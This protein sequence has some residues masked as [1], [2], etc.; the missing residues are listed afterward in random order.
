MIEISLAEWLALASVCALGAMSP[1]PSLFVVLRAAVHGGAMTGVITGLTHA[2]GVGIY[3]IGA[4]V[5]LSGAAVLGGPVLLTIQ[6]AGIAWLIW[7]SIGLWNAQAS[8]MDVSVAASARDGFLIVFLNPKMLAFFLALF[9]PFVDPE[10]SM[11]RNAVLVLTPAIIDGAWYAFAAMVLAAPVIR[12]RLIERG[13]LLNRAMALVLS[14]LAVSLAFQ[15]V[16]A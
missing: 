9:S 12:Q 13:L 16:N 14:G 5:V 8:G 10:A 7:L 15:L 3:A 1:G 4:I 11:A 6:I 2:F